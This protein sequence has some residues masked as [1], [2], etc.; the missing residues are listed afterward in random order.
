MALTLPVN[1]REPE[2]RPLVLAAEVI[3]AGGIVVYPTETLY[4]LGAN[5]LHTGAIQRV[6]RIKKRDAD[7]ELRRKIGR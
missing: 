6:R 3:Q 2:D 1:L 5:A 7:R 4:G